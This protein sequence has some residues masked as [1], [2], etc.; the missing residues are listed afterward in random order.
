MEQVVENLESRV[1]VAYPEVTRVFIEAQNW[2]AHAR[3]AR[4]E[5]AGYEEAEGDDSPDHE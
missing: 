5:A 3:R 4:E 1:R 2:I